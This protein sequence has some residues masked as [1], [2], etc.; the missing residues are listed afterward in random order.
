MQG[1]VT[2]DVAK[3]AIAASIAFPP[4][5]SISSA[6]LAES[7]CPAQI[8]YGLIDFYISLINSMHN[9]QLKYDGMWLIVVKIPNIV[10]SIHFIPMIPDHL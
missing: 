1:S 3:A 5:F 9:S 4:L 6:D 7:S 8:A 10:N 2:H